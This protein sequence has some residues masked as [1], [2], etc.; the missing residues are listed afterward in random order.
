MKLFLLICFCCI[1][2]QQVLSQSNPL[3]RSTTGAAGSSESIVKGDKAYVI[4][5]SVGQSSAIGTYNN[6]D[7]ML[8]QGFIQPNVL[9][10]IID[11]D[12]PATLQVVIYPNPFREYITASFNEEMLDIIEVQVYDMLGRLVFEKKYI[13]DESLKIILSSLPISNYVLKI[14]A[15]NNQFVKKIIKN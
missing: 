5:Q 2:Q 3:V 9:A 4:Q 13:A 6:S 10:K 14:K 7:Y 12:I 1:V 15:N 11:K 8:R